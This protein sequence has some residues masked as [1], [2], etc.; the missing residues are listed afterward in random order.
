MKYANLKIEYNLN[1]V[2][3]I[4]AQYTIQKHSRHAFNISDMDAAISA[5]S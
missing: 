4:G 2:A 5:M 1:S 3:V